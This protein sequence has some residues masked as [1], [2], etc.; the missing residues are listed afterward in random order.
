MF[1]MMKKFQI[2]RMNAFLLNK[3]FKLNVCKTFRRGN[4]RL[5]DVL[6]MFSLPSVSRELIPKSRHKLYNITS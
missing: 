5:L 3:G 4:G 6:C 2:L 1:Y